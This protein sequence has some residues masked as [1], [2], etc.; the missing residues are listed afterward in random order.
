MAA[1]QPEIRDT[2]GIVDFVRQHGVVCY[3][4]DAIAADF[5]AWRRRIRWEARRVRTRVS[6]RRTND[7]VTISNPDQCV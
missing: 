5:T 4:V 2:V 1:P 7:I 6:V 3:P